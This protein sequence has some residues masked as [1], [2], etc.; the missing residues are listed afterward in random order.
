MIKMDKLKKKFY[1]VSKAAPKSPLQLHDPWLGRC[2]V[3]AILGASADDKREMVDQGT[4]DENP[5]VVVH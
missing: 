2:N 5:I 1:N 4:H 3:A